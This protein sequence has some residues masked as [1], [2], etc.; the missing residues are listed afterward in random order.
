MPGIMQPKLFKDY[1]TGNPLENKAFGWLQMPDELI[2]WHNSIQ[3][4]FSKF[5]NFMISVSQWVYDE[6]PIIVSCHY[7]CSISFA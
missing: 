2:M 6:S 4:G 5:V 3:N 7:L 1:R